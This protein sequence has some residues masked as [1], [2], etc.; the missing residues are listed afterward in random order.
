MLVIW[1]LQAL[2]GI[3]LVEHAFKMSN[4]ALNAGEEFWNEFP[5][6]RRLD[7]QKWSRLRFYPGAVTILV[8]RAIG[9]F[10]MIFFHGA[11][12]KIIYWKD[13]YDK[14]LEQGIRRKL[15]DFMHRLTPR[16]ILA[17]FGCWTNYTEHYEVDYSKY[18]GPNWKETTKQWKG[19]NVPVM[20]SNHIGF[21]EIPL[22]MGFC[23]KIPGFVASHFIKDFPIGHHY[24]RIIQS[25]YV[26]RTADKEGLDK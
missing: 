16:T 2:L 3:Y 11:V 18:L 23:P 6:Y 1:V 26:D 21:L 19:T 24:T 12:T 9:I 15:L 5:G 22:W 10:G 17:L 20:A 7:L 8:P 13:D 14:P 4:R 25:E